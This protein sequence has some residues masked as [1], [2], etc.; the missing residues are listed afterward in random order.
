MAYIDR[1]AAWR[2]WVQAA[3]NPQN[4]TRRKLIVQII[5]AQKLAQSWQSYEKGVENMRYFGA[6]PEDAQ[7]S[8]K[9]ALAVARRAGWSPSKARTEY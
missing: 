1:V 6:C 7:E 2:A 9:E 8:L 3:A 4:L 5:N